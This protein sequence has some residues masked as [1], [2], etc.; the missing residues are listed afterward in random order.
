V[1]GSVQAFISLEGIV[2]VGAERERLERSIVDI[3]AALARSEKKL[4]NSE[5]V[6]KAPAAVVAK[7]SAKAAEARGRLEKLQAQLSELG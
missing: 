4:G 6:S 7:E 1:A 2:D 3:E 5:F